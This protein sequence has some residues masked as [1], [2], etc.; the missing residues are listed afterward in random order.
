MPKVFI[1][2]PNPEYT[3]MFTKRGWDVVP[4]IQEADLI[5]F[6]GGS[7]V[8]PALYNQSKHTTTV[9]N[10]DRDQKEAV[11]FKAARHFEK[12]MAGICRGG[13]FLNVMNGGEM[14]QDVDGHAIGQRHRA[15]DTRT[16]EEFWVTS[17]H[18]Q[19]MMP[20]TDGDVIITAKES[21]RKERRGRPGTTVLFIDRQ[22]DTPDVEAVFYE[23]T[24]SFCFQPHPEFGGCDDLAERYL[25]YI[26]EF[27]GLKG[28]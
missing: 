10:A 2:V 20:S 7:D 9:Y 24:R 3:V 4:H 22:C 14:W 27:F 6:T 18:H 26:D 16:G 11:I 1:V 13:Q 12:P 25:G 28:E 17:T 5:Q 19:M 23:E 8:N 15:L 21:T